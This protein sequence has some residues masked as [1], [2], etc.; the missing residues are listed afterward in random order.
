MG[1]SKYCLLGS[2]AQPLCGWSAAIAVA[3]PV[4]PTP[5]YER[6]YLRRYLDLR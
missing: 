5:H 4:V 3:C 1:Q 6:H 2:T